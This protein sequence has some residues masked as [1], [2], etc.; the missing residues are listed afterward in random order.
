MGRGNMKHQGI[1]KNETS[2][3]VGAT[4]IKQN[5]HERIY[6]REKIGRKQRIAEPVRQGK[7]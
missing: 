7:I 2:R 4:T 1:K 3:E 5:M 6:M